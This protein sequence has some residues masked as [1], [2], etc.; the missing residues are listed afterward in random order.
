MLLPSILLRSKSISCSPAEE[1]RQKGSTKSVLQT[2]V[3]AIAPAIGKDQLCLSGITSTH[4]PAWSLGCVW[5]EI[6][7]SCFLSD[8]PAFGCIP[9]C[10]S[11]P[12][13]WVPA[14]PS[15]LLL[16][17]SSSLPQ[18]VLPCVTAVAALMEKQRKR[19]GKHLN[20][21]RFFKHPTVQNCLERSIISIFPKMR[22]QPFWDQPFLAKCCFSQEWSYF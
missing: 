7:C 17:H 1:E 5:G 16:V 9:N 3:N 14:V 8:P 15:S 13:V 21:C 10:C 20:L 2:V 19:K 6:C 4:L 12:L 18:V 22:R 11:S